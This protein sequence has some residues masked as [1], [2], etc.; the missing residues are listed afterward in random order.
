M[1]VR[2]YESEK[3]LCLHISK[4]TNIKTIQN[5]NN[6]KNTPITSSQFILKMISLSHKHELTNTGK[7]ERKG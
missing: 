3:K 6:G 5:E 7:R 1:K 4:E 2:K